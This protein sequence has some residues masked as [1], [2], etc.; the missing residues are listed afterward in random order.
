MFKFLI[1][2]EL[3]LVSGITSHSF[4]CG[5]PVFPTPFIEINI[6]SGDYGG[7]DSDFADH[8]ALPLL[9]MG[10]PGFGDEIGYVH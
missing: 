8:A 3:I 7:H 1:H 2:F 10:F 4:A 6:D 9:Y 5:Y